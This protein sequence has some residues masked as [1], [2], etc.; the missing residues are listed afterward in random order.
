MLLTKYQI[1]D[2]PSLIIIDRQANIISMDGI[3]DIKKLTKA[4]LI[5]KWN[6]SLKKFDK[7]R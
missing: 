5:N 4:Q 1:R 2:L 6:D 7:N 3:G